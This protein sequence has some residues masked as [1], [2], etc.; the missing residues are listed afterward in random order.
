MMI[1]QDDPQAPKQPPLTLVTAAFFAGT[2]A[3]ATA[4]AALVVLL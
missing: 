2:V 4:V 3:V 1:A